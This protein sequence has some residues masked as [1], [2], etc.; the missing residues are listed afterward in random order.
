V[1]LATLS[2]SRE[3]TWC[4][5]SI[6][7]QPASCIS[8]LRESCKLLVG[9]VFHAFCDCDCASVSDALFILRLVDEAPVS[10]L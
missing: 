1:T 9:C 7:A 10:K 6:S 3:K 8:A 5:L 4:S 2:D